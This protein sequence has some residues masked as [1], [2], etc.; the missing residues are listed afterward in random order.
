VSLQ[1]MRKV[2]EIYKELAAY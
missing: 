1:N 2:V